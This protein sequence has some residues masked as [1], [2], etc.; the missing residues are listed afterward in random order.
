MMCRDWRDRR[1]CG[2]ATLV[3][4][5]E[6]CAMCAG[7]IVLARIPEV[8]FGAPDPKAGAAG[9]VL[10][11]LEELQTGQRDSIF[12]G[13]LDLDEVLRR[14][15]V[16]TLHVPLLE[17]THHL[18]DKRALSLM[19]PDALLI[20]TARGGTVNEDAVIDALKS[21]QLG[22]AA[23]DV[24][25]SEPVSAASGARFTG[26]ANLVLTPHIAGVTQE[27]NVRVSAVT[28]DN[29]RRALTER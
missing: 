5:L 10:D 11:V 13:R 19:K 20:N 27:S 16:L 22:G 4:T 1:H 3:V 23:L 17:H 29:V 24:F 26:I 18:I 12:E 25:E 15:D 21:G 2:G 28:A 14:S 8:V 9:S 6:P 7:A